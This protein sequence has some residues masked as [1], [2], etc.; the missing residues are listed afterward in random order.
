ML[1]V[2]STS[3]G[4]MYAGRYYD[5]NDSAYYTDPASTSRMNQIDLN[6]L[7]FNDGWD[8][9]DDDNDTLNIRSNNSDHGEVR[10]RDS[11]TYCGRIYWDDDGSIM[12][13]YHDNG[14]AILYADEN[15]ITYL[16]YNGTWEGR[17]RSS[18]FEARGSFRAP[19]FYDQNNTGYYMDPAGFTNLNTGVRAT[20]FYARN[21]F[22][23]DNSGEGLYN[24]ATGQHF[25]SDDDDYWNIAGGTGANA[26]RFRDEWGGTVRGYCYADSSNNVGILNNGASWRMRIVGG[27]YGLFDGS[28]VR[29][30]LFYDSNDTTY[31]QNPAGTSVMNAI[32]AYGTI[33]TE[34]EVT[35]FANYSDIRWKENVEVIKDA[36][37]KI[38]TL[39]GITYNYTDKEGNY[40][41]VIAQQVEKVLPEAVYET[42]DIKTQ[43]D[44]KAVRYGNMVGLLIEG[45]KE[46]Q[47]TINKQQNQLDEQ[48]KQIDKL[49]ELV[50]KLMDK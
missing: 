2:N 48:Q 39:D 1:D 18:Y 27:D 50:Y 16:Y 33:Q 45:I 28:S 40:T 36:I 43:K 46:Q 17:T 41:G 21:W 14:E 31:Y 25:Y 29:A 35:G 5:S 49:Q 4:S 7:Q 11:D 38:Q 42:Q 19:L 22:R 44:R 12:S 15:Y 20:E 10:F 3:G 32:Q 30:P 47:E 9:Y 23:N 34:G 26:I 6:F 8:I 37:E 24:Q 13:L